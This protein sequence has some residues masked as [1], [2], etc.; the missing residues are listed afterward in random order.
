MRTGYETISR[1]FSGRG[2]VG[3]DGPLKRTFRET[4][5]RRP[6]PATFLSEAERLRYQQLP[7]AVPE[8]V[9]RQHGQLSEADHQLL[10][11]QR[12]DVKGFF[13]QKDTVGELVFKPLPE[14]L[15]ARKRPDEFEPK[16]LRLTTQRFA[17]GSS[18]W[19]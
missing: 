11:G 14:E 18:L 2:G 13:F 4:P 9:L 10:R 7:P 5:F 3:A 17:T 8:S 19:R 1:S 6:M 12:R 15:T 16:A